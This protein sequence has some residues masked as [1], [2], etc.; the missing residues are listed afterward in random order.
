MTYRWL[1][2]TAWAAMAAGAAAVGLA[3]VS[4]VRDV[5]ADA[6]VRVLTASDVDRL[7]KDPESQ[8]APDRRSWPRAVGPRAPRVPRT[9]AR[10]HRVLGCRRRGRPIRLGIDSHRPGR[11]C[12]EAVPGWFNGRRWSRHR[13][14]LRPRER[15]W[16]RWFRLA[17]PDGPHAVREPVPGADPAEFTG[18]HARG[19]GACHA[20]SRPEPVRVAV[21]DR[22][23]PVPVAVRPDPSPTDPTPSPSD[24]S[25]TPAPSTQSQRVSDG[26]QPESGSVRPDPDADR[27]HAER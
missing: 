8:L 6:P 19:V 26:S 4:A 18:A 12:P 13:I 27:P 11:C 5:V 14:H 15:Y 9:A 2:I 7:L 25:P 17:H 3:A 24:P 21:A 10:G 23:D 1:S 16:P 22:P 20:D